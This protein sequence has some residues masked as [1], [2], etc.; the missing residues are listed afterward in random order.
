MKYPSVYLPFPGV[1]RI[2]QL[3]ENTTYFRREL[4][5]MG[6]II[7]G[8]DDSPVVPMMLY[9]PAKIGYGI[10]MHFILFDIF[11]VLYTSEEIRLAN[12]MNLPNDFIFGKDI[13]A[14]ALIL[15]TCNVTLFQRESDLVCGKLFMM[16][17]SHI[18]GNTI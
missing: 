16:S 8:N 18:K 9:M 4:R 12:W 2:R 11:S 13:K 5:E 6:F 17:I 3:S 7:Y 14:S 10:P 1:D 15:M